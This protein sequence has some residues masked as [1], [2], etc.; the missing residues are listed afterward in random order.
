MAYKPGPD[1][2]TSLFVHQL[3][4]RTSFGADPN[5]H[6]RVVRDAAVP[7]DGQ[8]VQGPAAYLPLRY[9]RSPVE[10][11]SP[12][13]LSGSMMLTQHVNLVNFQARMW[14]QLATNPSILVEEI[15]P[16]RCYANY[17]R[18]RIT[19]LHLSVAYHCSHDG[20]YER[21]DRVNQ[22]SDRLAKKPRPAPPPSSPPAE[23]I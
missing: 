23:P 10:L 8:W 2:S 16:F 9:I 17:I 14:F 15:H 4:C 12:A 3:H 1:D 13:S 6:S 19:L 20:L 11:C 18:A 22:F 21:G 7:L 5:R